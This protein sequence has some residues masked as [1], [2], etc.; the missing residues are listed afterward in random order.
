MAPPLAGL[1]NICQIITPRAGH[2]GGAERSTASL[3]EHLQRAGHRVVVGCKQGSPLL[4][5][6]RQ[7]GLDARPLALSGKFNLAATLR[8]ARLAQ[9]TGAAVIHSHL[10][11]AAWHASLAGRLAR[12]PTIAHVRAL[13]DAFW[14]RRAGR[15]IAVSHAVKQHLV[16]QGVDAGTI[17]VVYNGVDPA[18]YFLPCTRAEA[19]ARLGLPPNALVTGV[20]GHLTA[21]KG[22][23]VFLDGFAQAAAR[24]PSALALLVGAGAEREA[25]ADQSKRLGISHQVVFAGFQADVLPYYAAM[26]VVVLSSVDGE[27]LP[28]CLLEGG[29]LGMPAIGTRLSGVPEIVL[30]GET[31]FVVPVGDASALGERLTLLLEDA[32]LRERMGR[33]A[34]E[35]VGATFTV[36]AMVAGT[37]ATYAKV[38]VRA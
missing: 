29:L 9:Q 37:L 19:R 6:M 38:G 4:D 35:Y 14:Y 21:K 33:A 32:A 7:A 23:A 36:D 12:L 3:C 25:L 30:D 11:S 26:D 18:R 22:H 17:D 15:L 1:M 31:G 34:R 5:A 10:S 20:V 27:G 24:H 13:N 28:R 8:V 2:I 16:A